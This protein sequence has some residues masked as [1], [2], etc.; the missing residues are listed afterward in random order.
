VTSHPRPAKRYQVFSMHDGRPHKCIAEYNS[1]DELRRH[2]LRTDIIE[3]VQIKPRMY[4]PLREYLA[5]RN[6]EGD[7]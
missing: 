2:P 7:A 4:V 3:V 5:L 1:L 6:D